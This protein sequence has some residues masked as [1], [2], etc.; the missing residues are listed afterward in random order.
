[1]KKYLISLVVLSLVVP[2]LVLAAWWNPFSWFNSWTLHKTEIAPIV[3]VETQKTPEEKKIQSDPTVV[4]ATNKVSVSKPK[5]GE[6]A[7][8]DLFN[9]I[10]NLID[11][12]NSS[13]SSYAEIQDF[14]DTR[15]DTI[16][17]L[18]EKMLSVLKMETDSC[19]REW[20]EWVLDVLD[21]EE[22]YQKSVKDSN[23]KMIELA[24]NQI[25]GLKKLRS[26]TP[27]YMDKDA[28]LSN[29][30]KLKELY[31]DIDAFKKDVSSTNENQRVVIEKSLSMW[32]QWKTSSDSCSSQYTENYN[33][34]R[35]YNYRPAVIPQIQIPKTTYCTMGLMSG[36]QS[37]YTITCN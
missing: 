20:D 12:Y 1:M 34:I 4:S 18:K 8:P 27:D 28:F 33:T 36:T 5:A 24:E 22:K 19:S 7:T 30:N 6:I 29:F 17:E 13:I 23:S 32:E 9:V 14:V 35:T 26:I 25:N 37:Y 31:K 10:D 21:K 15:I 16:S 11:D 2:Q 3:Q